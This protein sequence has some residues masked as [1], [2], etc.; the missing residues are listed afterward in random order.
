MAIRQTTGQRIKQ[1][2]NRMLVS[3][4]I[5]MNDLELV[6]RINQEVVE[7]IAL[8][9]VDP[10]EQ[11]Q[12][13]GPDGA[14]ADMGDYPGSDD[15]AKEHPNDGSLSDDDRGEK[16]ELAHDDDDPVDTSSQQAAEQEA[17]S[18]DIFATTMQEETFREELKQ[19]IDLLDVTEEERYLAHYLIDCLEEDGYLRRPLYELVDD[20]EFNQHHL[21]TEEDLEAVLVEIVQEELEPTG[22]GARDLR[23]CLLLQAQELKGTPAHRLAYLIVKDDFDDLSNKRYDVIMQRYGITSHQAWVDV[24]RTIRHL[25][26]KPGNMQPATAKSAEARQNAIRP[27]FIISVDDGYINVTLNDAMLPEVRISADEQQQ[28]DRLQAKAQQ[29]DA[30]PSEEDRKAL[31]FYGESFQRGNTFISCLEQRRNT[32]LTVMQTIV[33]M[34]RAY[35]LTGQVET[36]RPMTCDDVA[37]QC[38]YDLS[39]VSR[40][41]SEK[42]ADTEFGL[43][44]LKSL[45]SNA[46]GDTTQT[47]IIEALRDII[48]QEDKQ[49]PLTDEALAKALSEQGY[50]IARKT[51]EKY[52]KKI[53][54]GSAKERKGF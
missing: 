33:K 45:F 19:Q 13:Y 16:L 40:V 5:E 17:G 2:P 49:K 4:M 35:F 41:T 27:D 32:L 46:V 37:Q 25:N 28:Y 29:K 3:T 44:A 54:I 10:G 34:Q 6:Q 30:A 8:E 12:D 11:R 26:P 51:V 20:L 14:G 31:K 38:E 48:D 22:I 23:E 36:L 52:R 7:N 15:G 18:H 50:D 53:G 43:I 21:T 39:T 42:Y 47:A 9:I 24:L 1:S